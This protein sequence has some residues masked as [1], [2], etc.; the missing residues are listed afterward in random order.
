MSKTAVYRAILEDPL[1]DLHRLAYADLCEEEGDLDRA[2]FI[3]LQIRGHRTGYS[4]EDGKWVR[5]TIAICAKQWFN[6]LAIAPTGMTGSMP[7][8]SGVW[9]RGFPYA[10]Q[11]DF[12]GIACG[13][14]FDFWFTLLPITNARV[15]YA[16]P[17]CEV[18]TR[19]VWHYWF[20]E[21]SSHSLGRPFGCRLP[22]S[23]FRH[24]P[25]VYKRDGRF[26]YPSHELAMSAL[27]AAIV[28]LGR[29]LAK[30][31]PIELPW[32]KLPQK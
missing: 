30:L 23:V 5:E 11:C 25:P 4:R 27:S 24:L 29:E 3:R 21:E 8:V 31:P 14:N 20:N 6:Q 26:G 18:S 12:I 1:E 32:D 2:N 13:P 19:N 9:S 16:R 15:P 10:L 28:S 7:S 22:V 17:H